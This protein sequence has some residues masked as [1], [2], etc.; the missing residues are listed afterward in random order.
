MFTTGKW[1][2]GYFGLRDHEHVSSVALGVEGEIFRQPCLEYT[3][4][5]IRQARKTLFNAAAR[6]ELGNGH[7]CSFL[8]RQMVARGCYG[9]CC[10]GCFQRHSSGRQGKEK[11]CRCFD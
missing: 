3:P 8:D 5:P 6:V 1:R 4:E 11:C 10:A 9:G 7:R 2:P